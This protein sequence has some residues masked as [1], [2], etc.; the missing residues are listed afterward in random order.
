MTKKIKPRTKA[1]ALV[2]LR[3]AEAKIRRLERT[4][5]DS[6]SLTYSKLAADELPKLVVDALKKRI[7]TLEDEVARLEDEAA[8]QEAVINSL[9]PHTETSLEY[10]ERTRL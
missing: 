3:K 8:A 5:K 9:T 1:E 10:M 4:V 7:K 2:N 6:G